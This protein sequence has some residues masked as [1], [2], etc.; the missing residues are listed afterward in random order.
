MCIKPGGTAGIMILSQRGRDF[1]FIG[2]NENVT[3]KTM[4]HYRL[5]E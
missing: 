3:H 1:L 2:G 5:N 4:A